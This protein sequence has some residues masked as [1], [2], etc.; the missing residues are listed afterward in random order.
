MTTAG[1]PRRSTMNRSLFFGWQVMD[2]GRTLTGAR[3]TVHLNH[4][5]C[6]KFCVLGG[7]LQPALIQSFE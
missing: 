5:H 3:D 6:A 1:S 2:L 7:A 4:P